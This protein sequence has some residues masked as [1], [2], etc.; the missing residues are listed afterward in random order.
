MLSR[1]T[2]TE[3]TCSVRPS[4]LATHGNVGAWTMVKTTTSTK[5]RSKIHS[6]SGVPAVEGHGREHDGHGAAQAGPR[7]EGLVSPR[8]AEPRHRGDDRQRSRHEE[9]HEPDDDGR[10]ELGAEVS[11][12]GEQAE[13]DEEADLRQPAHRAAEALERRAVGQA[14]VGE[15][16]RAE[17]GREEARDVDGGAHGIREH[18]E[19]DDADGEEGRRRLR[20]RD[21][22]AGRRGRP[23][24]CRRPRRRRARRPRGGG[25]A[26]TAAS[27]PRARPAPRRRRRG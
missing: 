9:Q 24:R 20:R 4:R 2:S 27:R 7:Q 21:A 12:V 3:W 18:G 14:H 8:H 19:R 1:S 13:Q 11:R 23:P 10:H 15:H 16:E 25:A 26:T 22:A 5:T 17:V 6:V